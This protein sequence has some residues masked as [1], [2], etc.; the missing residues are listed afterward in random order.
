MS[1]LH[2]IK[3][4]GHSWDANKAQGKADCFISIKS[5]Y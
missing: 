2:E 1:T 4:E 3:H 5:L